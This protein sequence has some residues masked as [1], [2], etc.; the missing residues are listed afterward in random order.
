VLGR[1][2]VDLGTRGECSALV[3]AF[4]AEAEALVGRH[5]ETTCLMVRDD[6]DVVFVAKVETTEPVRLVTRVGSRLPAFAAASGRV[7][8]AALPRVEVDTL[9]AGAELVTPVG[10]EIEPDELHRILDRARVQGFA[11]NVNETSLGLRCMAVPI[12]AGDTTV[13]AMTFCV[14]TGR[15]DG[16]RRRRLLADLKAAGRRASAS[17]RAMTEPPEPGR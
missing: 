1:R 17:L 3:S 5:N 11:E 15:I 10:R 8:L 13:A 16:P 6:R 14:P 12:T 4:E 9:L 7:L 2:A